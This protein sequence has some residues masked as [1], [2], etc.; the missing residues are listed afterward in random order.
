M[1][2][3]VPVD[4]GAATRSLCDDVAIRQRTVV[5]G[6]AS[7][8]DTSLLNTASFDAV[9]HAGADSAGTILRR[10]DGALSSICVGVQ[11]LF[12]D[13]HGEGDNEVECW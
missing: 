6:R 4:S 12:N 11:F 10:F 3:Q 7:L 13:A 5:R 1:V 2:A 9:A 8:D